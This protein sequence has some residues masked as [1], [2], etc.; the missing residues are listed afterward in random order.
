MTI[1]FVVMVYYLRPVLVDIDVCAR[2][3]SILA[4]FAHK[5]KAFF[6]DRQICGLFSLIIHKNTVFLYRFVLK[7]PYLNRIFLQPEGPYFAELTCG[8]TF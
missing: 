6:R 7:H 4:K 3:L 1:S 2:Y 5:C 8:Y